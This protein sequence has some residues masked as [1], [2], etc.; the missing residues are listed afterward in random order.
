MDKVD[1]MVVI[2]K[3]AEEEEYSPEDLNH[4]HEVLLMILKDFIRFCDEHDISYFID[5][6]SALGC[7]RHKGFIPWDDDIDVSMFREDY[8]KFLKHRHE[9]DD[10]YEILNMEDYDDYCRMFAKVSLKGTRTGEFLDRNTD[11][12]Y[13]IN[14]DVFV[15]DNM[16]NPGF[17]RKLFIFQANIFRKILFFH[18]ITKSDVYMSKNK[19]RIGHFIRFLF[20]ILN[21]NNKTVKR[22]GKKLINKSKKIESDYY[23]SFGTPYSLYAFD[24][25]IY[26]PLIKAPFESV[27]VSIAHDY[28]KYFEI[29]FGSDWREL[30]PVEKR[31]NHKYDGFDFGKY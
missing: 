23:T 21:I 27:E 30:P 16:P 9:F 25:S 12:T 13:G 29:H 17:K 10:K 4:L 6:G 11:F 8:E 3:F 19:E 1:I 28:E 26:N 2:S 7:I 31:K 18:E 5:G 15:F 24:K 20:K 22:M 14:I